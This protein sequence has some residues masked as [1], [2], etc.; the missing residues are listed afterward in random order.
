MTV[1]P[2]EQLTFTDY[3]NSQVTEESNIRYSLA[4]KLELSSAAATAEAAKSKRPVAGRSS[5]GHIQMPD[6]TRPSDHAIVERRRVSENSSTSMSAAFAAMLVDG[7]PPPSSSASVTK[8]D[9]TDYSS[10]AVL[11]PLPAEEPPITQQLAYKEYKKLRFEYERRGLPVEAPAPAA[12]AKHKRTF[13]LGK[14]SGNDTIQQPQKTGSKG[15]ASSRFSG[16]KKK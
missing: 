7:P 2:V 14:S 9:A 10:M 13:S 1:F 16:F 6:A 11:P 8:H 15:A 5:H 3:G 4:R 12:E